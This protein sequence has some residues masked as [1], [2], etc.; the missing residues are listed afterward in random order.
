MHF[1]KSDDSLSFEQEVRQRLN[2]IE[3]VL[4]NFAAQNDLIQEL[5]R[6]DIHSMHTAKPKEQIFVVTTVKTQDDVPL[7]IRIS[8]QTYDIRTRIK[9]FG[10]ALWKGELKAWELDYSEERYHNILEYLNTLTTNIRE[11]L[12]VV[13]V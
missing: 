1:S 11:E 5:V 4:T 2:T 9:E 7:S 6:K 13:E 12:L 8:G 10:A 3:N